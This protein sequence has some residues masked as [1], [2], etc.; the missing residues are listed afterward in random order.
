MGLYED[1]LA[2]VERRKLKWHGHV[3][4]SDGLTKVILQGTVEG[5]RI[6]S[7]KE[8]RW[9]DN[10]AEW[11]GK[12]FAETSSHGTHRQ[13]WRELTEKSIMTRGAKGPM[14]KAGR[15]VKYVVWSVIRLNNTATPCA[16]R[17]I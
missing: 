11:T 10:T 8:K 1:L 16:L 7:M 2:T 12:F 15:S 17:S 13:E 5:Q 9:I 6:R 3:I 14:Q 4:R